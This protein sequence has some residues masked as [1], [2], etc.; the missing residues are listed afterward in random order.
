MIK[1][2]IKNEHEVLDNINHNKS[3]LNKTLS[4]IEPKRN[5]YNEEIE[6]LKKNHESEMKEY[7]TKI[8][9]LKEKIGELQKGITEKKNKN[10]T[11]KDVC[12]KK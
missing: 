6:K 4:N 7:D 8:N 12:L 3:E 5:S 1:Q 10:S 2:E 11:L 9:T